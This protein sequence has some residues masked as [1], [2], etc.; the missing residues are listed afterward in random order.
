MSTTTTNYGLI[1]PDTTDPILVGQLNDNMD[2]IDTVLKDHS[3]KIDAASLGIKYKGEVNYYADLPNSA[4]IGDA[5][6][7]KYSGSSG[8]TPDGTEYVWGTVSGT[9]QW[10]NFSKDSYTKAEVDALLALKQNALSS[11]Q[12]AAV[13]SGI[14]STKVAQI[15]TNK[16]NISSQQDTVAQGGNGYAI[17]NGIRQ[18]MGDTVTPPVPPNSLWIK[19]SI[20]VK[21]DNYFNA[22][23]F[24]AIQVDAQGNKRNGTNCGILPQGTY[25]LSATTSAPQNALFHTIKSGSTYNLVTITELPYTFTADGVSE[26]IIRV[27]NATTTSWAE[28]GYTN[29]MLNTG[30]TAESYTPYWTDAIDEKANQSDLTALQATVDTKASNAD[31]TALSETVSTKA[32]ASDLATTNATVA[33]KANASDVATAD[34]NLQA[35]IDNIVSGSTADSEVI[36][37]RVGANGKSYTTLKERLDSETKSALLPFTDVS[38]SN[39][40]KAVSAITD[41]VIYLKDTSKVVQLKTV[42]NNYNNVYAV[43]IW[44][45]GTTYNVL[46]FTSSAYTPVSYNTFEFELGYGYF[47]ID[48]SALE[49]NTAYTH[50][51]APLKQVFK[52]P[53]EEG[54]RAVEILLPNT[55]NVTVGH[56]I[57][58]EYYNIV[59]CTNIDNYEVVVSSTSTNIQNLGTR[60]RIAPTETGTTNETMS[61]V[62]DGVVI[63]K[64]SFDIVA[65]ADVKPQIKAIFL[66]DSMTNAAI[67]LAELVN[68]YGASL[69]LYGTRTDSA[70]DSD[71]NT[72]SILHEGRASWSTATYINEAS[73]RGVTNPFYNEGFDFSFYITNNPTF[74]D[75]T[76]VFILLGTNDFT[77]TGIETRYKTITDSIKAY[78]SNIRIH[79]MLPPPPVRDGYAWGTRNYIN[80]LT[81]KNYMFNT[82]KKIKTLYD[83]VSGYSIIPV[84]ANLDCKYDFPQTTVAVNSRNPQQIT[85][86]NDNV[87]PSKYGYYRFADAIYGDIIANCQQ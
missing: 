84:N 35:Q 44:V 10:I 32:A 67:Y 29:I 22:D 23:D 65:S 48:W 61:L 58:L 62:K 11:T 49:A 45:D 43:A 3:D 71:G 13:N 80:Y 79:C 68:M 9:N 36:N 42:Y 72:R 34:A 20:K 39:K 37:A 7:V 60:L 25:T 55:I 56:E 63:A 75:V 2:T 12:L 4:E 8:T 47:A 85:V 57:S 28:N 21:T 41:F 50:V 86:L 6:T 66:G 76:D 5:Y 78:N 51:N 52:K 19:D 38:D 26:Q 27:A 54:Y 59:N 18:Y 74:S 16:N 31:L 77:G 33:T 1:K 87:H 15:E 53:I 73:F 30:N 40:Q 17:I 81:F 46:N 69:T 24:G 70:I 14:D 64:K 82:A 83:G